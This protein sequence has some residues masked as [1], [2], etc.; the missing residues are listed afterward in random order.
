MS[1]FASDASKEYNWAVTWDFQQSAKPQISL[2]ICT[3]WSE[4]LLVA[5]IFYEC[6]ATDWTSFG[7][8]ELK[9]RLLR[10]V[11]VY[12]RQNATLCRG[13][14][15]DI[16]ASSRCARYAGYFHISN[17]RKK[18]DKYH[19]SSFS[20]KQCAVHARVHCNWCFFFMQTH[21]KET[22]LG[23]YV[24]CAKSVFVR[25]CPPRATGVLKQQHVVW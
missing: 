23:N 15:Y 16:L 6:L 19:K 24:W 5:W 21:E 3:V 18:S 2:R 8:C 20:C 1:D 11:W 10:L 13:S 14:I 25:Q 7:V 9:R 17:K 12:T 22:Q 4:P